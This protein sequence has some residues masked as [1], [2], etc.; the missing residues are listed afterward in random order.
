MFSQADFYLKPS[1]QAVVLNAAVLFSFFWLLHYLI[2]ELFLLLILSAF[3]LLIFVGW[4]FRY[5]KAGHSVSVRKNG[6]LSWNGQRFRIQ[7]N[8]VLLPNY[9]LL[10]LHDE[11]GS[12]FKQRQ[13]M[14][15]PDQ[16]DREEFHHLIRS[17]KL[18][19]QF[20]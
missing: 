16:C 4:C 10:C 11:Q 3:G 12:V 15:F 19:T 9:I 14:V 6:E 17:I 1:K 18:S 13:R 5:L 8:T 2:E 7:P 20:Y